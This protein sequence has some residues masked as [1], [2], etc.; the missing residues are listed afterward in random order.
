MDVKVTTDG[1]QSGQRLHEFRCSTRRRRPGVQVHRSRRRD[2]DAPTRSTTPI[3]PNPASEP[4]RSQLPNG[5]NIDMVANNVISSGQIAA[6][7]TVA[8]PDPGAGAV[9]GRSAGRVALQ[10]AV[11]HHH[12]RHGGRRRVRRAGFSLDMSNMQPGN[13]INLTYTNGDHPSS[14]CRSSTWPIR[15]RCRC[16]TRPTPI[17]QVIGVNFSGG[18]ASVVSPIERRARRHQYAIFQP[19]RLDLAG[20]Q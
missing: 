18:M 11:G 4:S 10:F 5:A 12:G 3:R 7:L 6:D 13:T 20:A 1:N 9:P 2:V 16:R 19:L 17:R 8:R 14:R 15:P